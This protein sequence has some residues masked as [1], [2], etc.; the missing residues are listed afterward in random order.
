MDL[1]LH[2]TLP[3]DA[4]IPKRLK[5]TC[6][7]TEA[8]NSEFRVRLWRNDD[9][10]ALLEENEPD[11]LRVYDG[12]PRNIQ[13]AD[14][15]RYAILYFCGGLYLDLDIRAKRPFRPLLAEKEGYGCILAEETQLALEFR[16]RTAT[17]PIRQGLPADQRP[18]CAF[19]VSNFFMAAERGNATMKRILDL[20]MA[21][22]GHEVREDYDVIFTTGP[23]VVSTVIDAHLDDDVYVLPKPEFDRYFKHLGDGDW[24]NR[25]ARFPVSLFR[26]RARDPASTR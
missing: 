24:K 26:R 9:V 13:R 20:C 22:S 21:R 5:R 23:D 1:V 16:E 10:R 14:F 7:R 25:P 11:Y 18:E 12:Y 19:R 6:R 15:A 8:R 4:E 3:W 17:F 2:R